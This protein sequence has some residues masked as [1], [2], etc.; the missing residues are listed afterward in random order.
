MERY[1]I[2]QILTKECICY[3]FHDNQNIPK[4]VITA[5]TEENK[6]SML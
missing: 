3:F 6:Q 4:M 5:N 2:A 1:Q